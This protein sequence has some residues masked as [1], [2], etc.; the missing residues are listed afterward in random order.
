MRH[1]QRTAD[2]S[3][4]IYN[5]ALKVHFHSVHGALSESLHVFI[6]NG[7]EYQ[8]EKFNRL[9]IL[10]VGLGT[11]LNVVLSFLHK[12][13]CKIHY[14][15]LEPDPLEPEIFEQLHF[16]IYDD[17]KK[18]LQ[19]IHSSAFGE[20]VFFDENFSFM[21]MRVKLEEFASDEKFD[22]IYFDAFAPN[23]QP[24]LWTEKMFQKIFDFT[25]AGGILVTYCAKGAVKRNLKN[26]GFYVESL[27][28]A[29]GKREMIRAVK[30]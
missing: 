22:V 2:G 6:K 11:G 12:G 21:K 28:G 9:N 24:E 17:E 14:T 5:D 10:E 16:N 25:N 13:T 20:N 29:P 30:N 4:T 27:S 7:L 8:K 15:A 23:A 19:C 1:L 18:L 26:C 3:L